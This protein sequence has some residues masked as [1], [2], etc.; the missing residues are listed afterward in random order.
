LVLLKLFLEPS[1]Y[2]MALG[3]RTARQRDTL[4]AVSEELEGPW[5]RKKQSPPHLQAR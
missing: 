4:L 1:G 2:R 5:D 3:D